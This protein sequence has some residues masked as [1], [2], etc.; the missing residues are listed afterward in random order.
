MD[1]AALDSLNAYTTFSALHDLVRVVEVYR[2][3]RSELDEIPLHERIADPLLDDAGDAVSPEV[4][5][6]IVRDTVVVRQSQEA[7]EAPVLRSIAAQLAVFLA[8]AGAVPPVGPD[9]R[10][11]AAELGIELPGQ[12]D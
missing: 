1:G 6:V 4:R 10:E 8:L 7:T 2:R 9:V 5:D 3:I 12:E 11:R